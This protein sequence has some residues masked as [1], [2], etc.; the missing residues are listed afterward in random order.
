M[1]EVSLYEET[2]NYCAEYYGTIASDVYNNYDLTAVYFS[3]NIEAITNAAFYS[4]TEL[5]T[6]LFEENS[7]C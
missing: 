2:Q 1:K 7:S 3:N 4:Q 5:K 6:I